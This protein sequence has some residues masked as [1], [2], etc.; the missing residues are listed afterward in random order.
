M[1]ILLTC[2]RHA[3]TAF[4]DAATLPAMATCRRSLGLLGGMALLLAAVAGCAVGEVQQADVPFVGSARVERGLALDE[5]AMVADRQPAADR[6]TIF[7]PA[8]HQIVMPDG[9]P[10]PLRRWGP[11]PENGESPRAVV[12]GVHGLNDHAGSFM[13][14]ASALAAHDVAVY[15]WDQRGFGGS[16]QRGEWP[17]TNALVADARFAS[18]VLRRRYPETPLYLMGISMGAAVVLLA[19]D[20]PRPPPVDGTLLVGPAVWGAAVMPWY[21][22]WA[23]W[24]GERLAPDL[25]FNAQAIGIRPTDREVVL[26]RLA[27]DP[28]W[29]RN[30][31]V[32]VMG[33]VA[34]LMDR[35]LQTLPRFS[36]PTSL[37]QYG[38][39]DE[40][41]PPEAACAMFQ[42]LPKG[43]PW[44][45]AVYPAG[46]HML[47][48]SGVA[49][50]VLGD[51]AAFIKDPDATLPSGQ[52]VDRRAALQAVCGD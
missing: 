36:G 20:E 24:I 19:A 2:I 39:K 25:A 48:R 28:L 17:G 14:T 34:D 27:N 42:R 29:I 31:R 11:A 33:G 7:T 40:I 32:E 3:S 26:D 49:N 46:F 1:T 21:Q 18:R 51:I 15:A 22:R 38:G 12:L 52:A 6:T 35:A 30:T 47:T 5:S 23:L 41:I 16:H 9:T 8:P 10:L 45:A 43:A 44:R 37:I 4:H 13:A 50:A